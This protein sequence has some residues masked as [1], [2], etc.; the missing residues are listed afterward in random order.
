MAGVLYVLGGLASGFGQV[1]VLGRLVV[2]GNA[3]AT[4]TN[5]RANEPLVWLV[6]TG[7][8]ISVACQIA[9]AALF[10]DLFT[11]VNRSLSLLAAFFLL[12][13]CAVLAFASLFQVAPLLVLGG[14]GSLTVFPVAQIQALVLLLLQLNAQAFDMS[15]VFF[16]SWCVLIGYLIVRSTF[17]P[18]VLGVLLALAGVGYLT[19]LSPPLAHELSPYNLAPAALGETSLMLWL[20]V[21]GVNAQ[22]WK[23]QATARMSKTCA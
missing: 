11:P 18:R 20:L 1:V 5:I 10:Y 8:L 23:E 12:M 6:F 17:L 3:A 15:L 19:F 9:L 16:G 14:G 4:A 21:M 22:R 13:E 7:A 2:A